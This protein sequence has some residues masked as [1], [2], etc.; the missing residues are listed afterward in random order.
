[1]SLSFP[2]DDIIQSAM[3]KFV[4]LITAL[5][6]GAIKSSVL[7]FNNLASIVNGREAI[8]GQVPYQVQLLFNKT[9][10]LLLCGGSLIDNQWVLTAGHC[11][12]DEKGGNVSVEAY[13]GQ[14]E[15]QWRLNGPE[16]NPASK[17]VISD[18]YF[19][20][21][22]YLINDICLVQLE[23]PVEFSEKV[24]P[25]ALPTKDQA[26]DE[27]VGVKA[28]ISG[29]GR[30]SATGSA[31]NVL[32][33][34]NIDIIPNKDCENFGLVSASLNSTVCGQGDYFKSIC[35]G[36]SGGPLVSTSFPPVLIGITSHIVKGQCDKGYPMVFARVS[37]YIDWIESVISKA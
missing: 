17:V 1:M 21:N 31:S 33:Y 29:W 10:I 5:L 37:S 28:Q 36:D 13:L 25:I 26:E 22:P 2:T 9:D 7:P 18:E 30:T 14:I 11:C 27:F 32:L 34:A 19:N 8:V 3:M 12:I 6:I 20:N 16:A 23:Y 4:F 35:E 24:Q 15:L